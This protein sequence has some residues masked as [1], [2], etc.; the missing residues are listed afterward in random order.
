MGSSLFEQNLS[1]SAFRRGLP[2]PR[3]IRLTGI[4]LSSS[5]SLFLSS[6]VK[7]GPV[8]CHDGLTSP[9]DCEQANRV[10]PA[11]LLF[12]AAT[13]SALA[14]EAALDARELLLRLAIRSRHRQPA[15]RTHIRPVFACCRRLCALPYGESATRRPQPS[16]STARQGLRQVPVRTSPHGESRSSRREAARL[17]PLVRAAAARTR[18][19]VVDRRS[20]RDQ[21]QRARKKK[22]EGADARLLLRLSEDRDLLQALRDRHLTLAS[23]STA[24]SRPRKELLRGYVQGRTP[25]PASSG[26]RRTG[27]HTH[28]PTLATP[29]PAR[30]DTPRSKRLT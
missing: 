17:F 18:F 10:T 13:K 28:Q 21:G 19:R 8:N 15:A 11:S 5:L 24:G 30:V 26:W 29:V 7:N 12:A 20:R 9:E 25:V 3:E 1:G 2:L 16:P 14:V 6:W 23:H 4:I 27:G 22:H